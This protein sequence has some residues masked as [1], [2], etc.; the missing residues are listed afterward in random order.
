MTTV[1]PVPLASWMHLRE[2]GPL[3][4]RISTL[5]KSDALG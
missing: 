3:S 4:E 1:L 2:N 5:C